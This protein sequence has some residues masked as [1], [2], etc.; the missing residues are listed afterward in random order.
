MTTP[1]QL[2]DR[3]NFLAAVEASGLLVPAQLAKASAA[4]PSNTATA[5]QTAQFL[6]ATGFLTRFQADRLLAGRTEGFILDPYVI[7]EQV[8]K[9]SVG[10][11]YCALHRTMNRKVAIKLISPDLT[12]SAA[13]RQAFQREVRAAARLNHPNIVTA[14]DANEV[15]ERF[16]LVME[17]VD[18]PNMDALVRERGPLPVAEACELVRQVAVGLSHAH[19][20]GMTHRDIKPA[21]LLVARASKTLPGCV[22]KIADFGIARLIPNPSHST[23]VTERTPSPAQLTGT[24]DYVAPEQALTPHLA[25]HRA[26]LYSL[27]CVFYFLLTGRPPFPGGTVETKV[28]RHQLEAP[29]AIERLRPDI[30][31]TVAEIVHRLLAKDPNSRLQ[32]A[33]GLAAR[34]DGLAAG[35]V[36]VDD[37]GTVVSFDLPAA[38]HGSYSFSSNSLTGMQPPSSA[39]VPAGVAPPAHGDGTA[40]TS[41]WSQLTDEALSFEQDERTEA[42]T[43]PQTSCRIVPARARRSSGVSAVTVLVLCGSVVACC[44]LAIGFFLR[45]MARFS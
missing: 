44:M 36:V 26:D 37:D 45:T 35:A 27:G 11:V 21:N 2:H 40:E 43:A 20:L 15:G 23:S 6:V 30:P 14:Y 19:E 17:F 13:A 8:G 16:Y 31:P 34:L 41:P 29:V 25:D 18:G 4:L 3:S 9:G 1:A 10:R 7:Q 28:R 38:Q 32:T 24:P 12:R 39:S 5:P 42:A 33:A 22:V